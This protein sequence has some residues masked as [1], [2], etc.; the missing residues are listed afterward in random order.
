PAS[1]PCLPIITIQPV[2]RAVLT[3]APVSFTVAAALPSGGG[4]LTYQWRRGGT[5]LVNGCTR[6]GATSPTL[7]ISPAAL[8]DNGKAFDCI[9][10]DNCGS[11]TSTPAG[12]AVT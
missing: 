2:D 5:N 1:T 10:S 9:V 12:L 6:S 8:S 7:T 4:S 3:G 11:V